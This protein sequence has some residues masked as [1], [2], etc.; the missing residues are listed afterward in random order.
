MSTSSKKVVENNFAQGYLP[1]DQKTSLREE[2]AKILLE[3]LK[4]H[5]SLPP[6]AKSLKGKQKQRAGKN[7]L[8]RL[9]DRHESVL[10][11]I[12]DFSVPF[13]NNLGEQDIRMNKVKQKVSGCF[14]TPEGGKIFCRIRSYISTARKQ[15][16]RIWDSLVDAVRGAPRLLPVP[17]V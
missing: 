13:T 2:Y 9:S 4:Y 12:E 17:T 14:R 5:M 7:L 10:M 3:G 6:L 16:W 15:G 11:F 1:E 8:N